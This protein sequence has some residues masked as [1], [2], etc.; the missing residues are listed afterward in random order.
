MPVGATQS[1]TSGLFAQIQQLQAQRSVDQAEQ[2]ARTLQDKTRQAQTVADRAQENARAL[3]VES[4]QA[5]GDAGRARQGLAARES[6]SQLQ[7]GYA[8]LRQQ[9][10][11]VIHP[12]ETE[13]SVA[14]PAPVVNSFGQET[15]TLVNVTA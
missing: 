12:V 7:S 3:K 15:G 4:N 6:I 2:R 8:D 13:T 14:P 5:Q 9:I 11:S 1:A 10:A